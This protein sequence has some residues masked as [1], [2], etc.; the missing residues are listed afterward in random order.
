[1]L[2]L[3]HGSEIRKGMK[4]AAVSR[5]G[6]A[7]WSAGRFDNSAFSIRSCGLPPETYPILLRRNSVCRRLSLVISLRWC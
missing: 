4:K 1:M 6:G 2:Q 5:M 7:G 3:Y